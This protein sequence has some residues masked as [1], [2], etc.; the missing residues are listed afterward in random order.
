[1]H[2]Y[3]KRNL[4]TTGVLNGAY[5]WYVSMVFWATGLQLNL[6]LTFSCVILGMF[7]SFYFKDHLRSVFCIFIITVFV[8]TIIITI[9]LLV[10]VLLLLSLFLLFIIIITNVVI[11]II[12]IVVVVIIT[13]A[14]VIITDF[15][16]KI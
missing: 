10:L 2:D 6:V 13:I 3:I 7:K 9:L 5:S 11:F 4:G 8:I 14:V 15:L 1:M 16:Y 12:I